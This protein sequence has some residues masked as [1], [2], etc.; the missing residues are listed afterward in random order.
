MN[1]LNPFDFY[2]NEIIYSNDKSTT[3]IKEID[4]SS[5]IQVTN[6]PN[7]NNVITEEDALINHQYESI[8]I[9]DINLNN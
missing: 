9:L 6:E 8:K 5:E 2:E 1:L 4:E 7:D 3:L